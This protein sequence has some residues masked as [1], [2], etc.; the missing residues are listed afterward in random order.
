MISPQNTGFVNVK[1]SELTDASWHNDVSGAHDKH[2]PLMSSPCRWGEPHLSPLAQGVLFCNYLLA[3]TTEIETYRASYLNGT[4]TVA[5]IL[6]GGTVV[7]VTTAV[8][9]P[10]ALVALSLETKVR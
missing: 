7:L 8:A 10:E 1:C 9:T 4:P 3:E 6:E 5:V 2:R